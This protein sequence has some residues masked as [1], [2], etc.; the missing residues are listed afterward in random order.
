MSKNNVD[1]LNGPL[2]K[3]IILFALPIA[4]GSI[5]QQLFNS[6][7][8]AVVSHFAGDAAL[9]AVGANT[10]LIN[11]IVNLFTGISVGANVMLAKSFGRGDLDKVKRGVHTAVTTA[12]TI[13]VLFGFA[14]IVFGRSIHVAMGTPADVI[15]DAITYFRI[16]FVGVPFI[17]LYNFCAAILRS[18]GDSK[19]PLICLAAAGV[20]N[21]IL[22][23]FF[24][25]VLHMTVDGVATATVISNVFSAAMVFMMLVKEQGP[26]HLDI[27]SLRLEFDILGEI[28]KIGLPAGLQGMFISLSNIIIQT[29]LNKLGTQYV[30]A[31]TAQLTFDNMIVFM[32]SAFGSACVTFTSQNYGAKQI[33]RC[34]E[35]VKKSALSG[36]IICGSMAAIF[37]LF[38]VP[39]LKIFISDAA[40]LDIAL[41]RM[42]MCDSI[43]YISAIGDS[44]A[45]GTRGLGY[46]SV[47]AVIAFVCIV[48][49]RFI[50]M[51]FVYP[52]NPC[53]EMIV[54]VFP[55]AW[56][57]TTISNIV[58]YNIVIRKVESAAK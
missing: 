35:V 17:F 56:T 20:L 39:L 53:Y 7:D 45:G 47:P 38:R 41:L 10:S 30:S 19:R 15:E 40:I 46:S 25:I 21:V 18:R 44:C 9:A 27:H 32:I 33:S 34:K 6:A 54:I 48:V 4:F 36:F 52:N 29:N 26:L 37:Y 51:L 1:M 23:L 2:T 57:L 43:I 55:I 24:V 50:W 49:F 14:A 3:K 31:N 58:A 16:Y 42:R 8:L 12:L 28:I 5:L 11:L 22:N 13:G